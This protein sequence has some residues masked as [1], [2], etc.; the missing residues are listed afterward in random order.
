MFP[1]SLQ[2]NVYQIPFKAVVKIQSPLDEIALLIEGTGKWQ[3]FFYCLNE[4]VGGFV[5]P[6]VL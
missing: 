3:T 1:D 5:S 4:C 2:F 6:F